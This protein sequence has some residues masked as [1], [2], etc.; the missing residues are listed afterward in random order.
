MA[1]FVGGSPGISYTAGELVE[2]ATRIAAHH[3]YVK[4]SNLPTDDFEPLDADARSLVDLA[5]VNQVP[6]I[7]AAKLVGCLQERAWYSEDWFEKFHVRPGSF[8]FGNVLTTQAVDVEVYSAYRRDTHFWNAFVNNAGAGVDLLNVPSLPYTFLPQTG[9]DNLSLQVTPNGPPVVDSTLDFVFDTMTISPVITLER[10]VLFEVLPELPY[11]EELEFLTDVQLHR[12][13]SEHRVSVRLYPRQFFEWPLVLLTPRER[14]QF[15]NLLFDWQSRVFGIAMWHESTLLASAATTGDLVLNVQSTAYADYREG[16][17][18]TVRTPAGVSTVVEIA[19]GGIA[20]TSL[21]LVTGVTIDLPAGSIVAPLRTAQA[22]ARV[23]GSRFTTDAA[24][25]NV[26]FRV[27]DNVVDLASTAGWDT[28]AG[29][30]VLN[31][32]ASTGGDSNRIS[33]EFEQQLLVFDPGVGLVDVAT[34]EDRNRRLKPRIFWCRG[35]Q[36]LWRIR[37]LLHALRG[38]Q[39]SFYDPTKGRDLVATEDLL[40]AGSALTVENVG[41]ALYVKN[42]SPRNVI[43]VHFNDGSPSLVR[44][45]TASSVVDANTETLTVSPAWD[46]DYAVET[47][48]RIEFLELSRAASDTLRIEYAE[49]DLTARVRMSTTTL[50]DE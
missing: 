48:E 15:Y 1:S 28:Y 44:E 49:G 10:L 22:A 46:A 8:E 35:K 36:Q 19:A 41:Y 31:D 11:A 3:T 13:G 16:K 45:I 24:T 26:R 9:L 4:P 34:T 47:I 50:L 12:D 6:T 42:R 7:P 14:S 2:H 27:T 29:K 30:V 39:V 18:A 38:R 17:L 23:A 5:Y 37:Q 20:A 32:L 33:E 40:A 25:V 43:Q 21:T